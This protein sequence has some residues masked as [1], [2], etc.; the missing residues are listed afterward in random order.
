VLGERLHR[1]RRRS[2]ARRVLGEAEA[3]FAAL[4]AEAWRARA[5][6]LLGAASPAHRGRASDD[7]LTAQERRVA[8]VA[9]TGRTVRE[10]A[11]ELRISPKTLDSHLRQVYAK[12]GI[13]SRAELAL[14]ASERGWLD[15]VRRG[16]G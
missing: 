9:A 7:S 13:R 6:V 14:I 12:L 15:A 10:A 8:A 3:V 5:A 2:R 11:L 1:A 4:G 16:D